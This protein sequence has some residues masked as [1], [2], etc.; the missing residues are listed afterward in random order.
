MQ[1]PSAINIAHPYNDISLYGLGLEQNR[2]KTNLI[3]SVL[4]P[5]ACPVKG[6]KLL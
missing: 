4:M 2:T 1:W 5:V 3:L 6:R